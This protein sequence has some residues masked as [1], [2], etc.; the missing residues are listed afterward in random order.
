MSYADDNTLHVCSENI[1][2][3]LKRLQEVGKMLF[4]WFTNNSLN[5]NANKCNLILSLD[6]FF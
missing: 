6:E 2:V 3:T 1:D 5:T 4:E